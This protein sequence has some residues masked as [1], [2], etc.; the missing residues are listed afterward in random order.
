MEAVLLNKLPERYG[1]SL[2][3]WMKICELAGLEK[4]MEFV[5][6]LKQA[7]G[8][9]H[10]EAFVLTQIYFNGGKPVYG[11]P[12]ALLNDQYK[13][14]RGRNLYDYIINRTV[15]DIGLP[16]KIG[17]CKG[18]TSL[19]GEK[20]FAVVLPKR[21]EIWIG[22]ALPNEEVND[23]LRT[24]KNIGG[25]DKINRYISVSK[26]EDWNNRIT[27]YLLKSYKYNI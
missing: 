22:L 18:Y 4:K 27:E 5:N 6:Y 17:I 16:I 26:K 23:L 13:T 15:E 8:I 20:Q 19:M 12:E 3:E 10:G 21:K 7:Y 11:D 24:T 25:S 9:K 1:K 14:E 2:S